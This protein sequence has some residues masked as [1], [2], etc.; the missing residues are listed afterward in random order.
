MR[1]FLVT[2]TILMVFVFGI[3]NTTEILGTRFHPDVNYFYVI[4]AKYTTGALACF[5]LAWSISWFHRKLGLSKRMGIV[6]AVFLLISGVSLII[7]L[8]DFLGFGH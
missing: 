3:L 4:V 8:L 7:D 1:K 6:G 2:C 5:G